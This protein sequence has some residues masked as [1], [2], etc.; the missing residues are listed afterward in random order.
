M[1]KLAI[2]LSTSMCTLHHI[3]DARVAERLESSLGVEQAGLQLLCHRHPCEQTGGLHTAV[4]ALQLQE[5]RVC[6]VVPKHAART[7]RAETPNIVTE[8]TLRE[9]VR[10]IVREIAPKS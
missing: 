9:I 3:R 7:D 10:E 4:G 6:Y 2:G 1:P 8:H 5:L